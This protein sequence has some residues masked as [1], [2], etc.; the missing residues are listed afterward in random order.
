MKR[1]ATVR[2]C[3]WR[4]F[5]LVVLSC[6][7]CGRNDRDLLPPAEAAAAISE[8]L[9]RQNLIADAEVNARANEYVLAVTRDRKSADSIMPEF[10]RWLADW[11]RDHPERAA[12]ARAWG[13][14]FLTGGD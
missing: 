3:G 11:A 13:T 1:S 12:D 2:I 10:H 9:Y 4:F 8:L 7:A 5:A 14:P 6:V